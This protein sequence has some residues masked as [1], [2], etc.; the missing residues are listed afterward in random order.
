MRDAVDYACCHADA[1]HAAFHHHS[2]P[3]FAIISLHRH[4]YYASIYRLPGTHHFFRL[5]LIFRRFRL[6][7]AFETLP[8]CS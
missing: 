8:R 5:L 2:T 6:R 1:R 4:R 7:Y 3:L